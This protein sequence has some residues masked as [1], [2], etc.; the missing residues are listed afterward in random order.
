MAV[1]G[2][3]LVL[4]LIA[5]AVYSK[6]NQR[7]SLFNYVFPGLH[8]FLL[9]SSLRSNSSDAAGTNKRRRKQKERPNHNDETRL[10]Q[11]QLT[12]SVLQEVPFFTSLMWAINHFFFSTCVYLI[13]EI[14][15][16]F[17]PMHTGTNTSLIWV[18]FTLVYQINVIMKLTFIRITSPELSHERN[19]LFCFA[20]AL[21]L[22]IFGMSLF[23]DQLI[24]V[25]FNTSF[26]DLLSSIN[27]LLASYGLK[28]IFVDRNEKSQI[29][30]LHIIA[31]ILFSMIGSAFLFPVFQYTSLHA[32]VLEDSEHYK[33][34]LLHLVF[35]CPLIIFSTFT[36][37]VS[38]YLVESLT[39]SY[40]Q[41]RAL[42]TVA[43]CLWAV[44][45]IYI[46][47]I[48]LQKF[49]DRPLSKV[50]EFKR[51]IKDEERQRKISYYASYFC[52]A[53]LQYFLPV[54]ITFLTALLSKTLGNVCLISLL[55]LF[56]PDEEYNTSI[57]HKANI[58]LATQLSREIQR[59]VWS[60]ILIA[61]L[62]V[63]SLLSVIGA[64]GKRSI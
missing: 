4:S 23:S 56:T 60:F 27:K 25:H 22:A 39:I 19:I 38:D 6:F 13:S 61:L 51:H 29:L 57:P 41:L 55:P 64:I 34:I 42:Q 17:F 18:F 54:T 30:I 28:E 46:A 33:K 43:I 62:C 5:A 44:T 59:P 40:E 50:M 11:L 16:Y 63:H 12:S 52:A 37:P 49:L 53:S 14:F 45:R 31:S 10:V 15:M 24:V 8:Y 7:C 26:T 1:F 58:T 2:F 48:F 20:T 47:R 35:F 21:F 32:D 9:E 3:H 36:K